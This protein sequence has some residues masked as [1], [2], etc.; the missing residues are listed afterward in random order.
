MLIRII[1]YLHFLRYDLT[2]SSGDSIIKMMTA[3]RAGKTYVGFGFGAIQAGLF[4]YEATVSGAFD[5]LVVAEIVPET[6][7]A[8]RRANGFYHCNIAYPDRIE[9]VLIGPIQIENSAEALDR[10]R[11]IEALVQATEIGTAIP[12][13]DYY[14]SAGPGSVHRVLAEGLRQKVLHSG[15]RAVIYT[16]EN[17]NHAAEILQA[18]VMA[19]IPPAEQAAVLE[20]VQFLNTVIG[21]MSGVVADPTQTQAQGLIPVTPQ[22]QQAFLVESFNQILI[23][24]IQLDQP[25]FRGFDIF[26]EKADLLPFEETKLYGHNAVHALAAY[27]GAMLGLEVIAKL[28]AFPEIATFLRDALIKEAGAALIQKY[29]GLDPLFSEAGFH[30][31]ADD[32]LERMMNPYLMD[33]V[34]RVGR[35]PARKLGWNDRLIGAMRLALSQGI[36]PVRFAFGAAAALS[37]LDNTALSNPAAAVQPRLAALWGN[38]A[39]EQLEQVLIVTLV[40]E[41]CE[42]LRFW[43]QNKSQNLNELF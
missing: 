38:E 17:H 12:S 34:Q 43:R 4:L 25:F 26:V 5:R 3:I 16:A 28:R 11:L 2:Y 31:Y 27:V 10:T 13:I 20:R 33:T 15:P 37:Q 39:T 8:I 41:A 23:S 9:A 22:A 1:R 6:V 42:A 18:Q 32:L 40:Q 7:A 29:R 14:R 21:K 36:K 19:E 30:D 24:Q 35:D